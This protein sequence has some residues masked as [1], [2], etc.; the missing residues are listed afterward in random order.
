MSYGLEVT[1]NSGVVT[2]SN[3]YKP[4]VFHRRG[5]V[6]VVSSFSDRPGYGTVTFPTPITTTEPPS[7]FVRYASGNQSG[8][9]VY[10]TWLGSAGN[11]TGFRITS[12]VFGG[13]SLQNHFLDWV[14]CKYADTQVNSGYGLQIFGESGQILYGS[15]KDI[16]VKYSKFTKAWTIDSSTVGYLD[17][18]PTGITIENDDYINISFLDRGMVWAKADN[19]TQYS[20]INLLSSNVRRFVVNVQLNFP[21]GRIYPTPGNFAVPICKFPTN[22]FVNT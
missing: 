21:S 7:L 14:A 1:N 2:I 10:Y 3:I 8:F 4:L 18:I 16:L 11:W 15:N 6:N 13:S 17:Y 22:V 12:G 9:S 5:T 19:N 20:G